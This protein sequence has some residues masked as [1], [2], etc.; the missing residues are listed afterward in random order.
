LESKPD[1][2]LWTVEAAELVAEVILL[3]CVFQ[4]FRRDKAADIIE[5]NA[6]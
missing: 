3:Q 2:A 1:K 6:D 5:L 4:E